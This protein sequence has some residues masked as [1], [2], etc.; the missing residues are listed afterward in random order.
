MTS[1]IHAL[2]PDKLY[3][4]ALSGG[5]DSIALAL[6]MK[7][8][9][10]NVLAL[11][12]NF[13]LRGE[14]SDRDE[15]FVRDFCHKHAIPLEVCHFDTLAS[16]REHKTSIEMEARD[17]RYRW[18]AQ[19]A[20][21]LDAEAICVAHHKDDQAETLLL[22]LIRGTGLK[23][24][25]AMHPERT[26]NGLRILR[27]L[28]DT[29]KE[30]ILNYLSHMEQDYVTDSTNLER[31]AL[32]NRIRLD[33]MPMLRQLNPNIT[34][35]LARTAHNVRMELDSDSE[36]SRYHRWLAQ[37]GFSRSQILD[38]YAHCE[39]GKRKTENGKLRVSENRSKVYFDYAEREQIQDDKVE[40]K[41]SPHRSP[42]TV[43]RSSGLTWHSATHTL[44]LDRGELILQENAQTNNSSA[45]HLQVEELPTGTVPAAKDFLNKAQAFV[46]AD[47]I[48]GELTLR[49]MRQGDRFRPYG[50]KQGSK[51]LS[52]FLTDRKVSLLD[53]QAQLVATD[54]ATNAIIWVVGREIDHRYRITPTTK[55]IL[56]LI[57]IG[58]QSTS[59]PSKV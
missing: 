32:R 57:C 8:Q 22:N 14:E 18:F 56:R 40:L 54:S 15:Q 28:L 9:H 38:I 3:L 27:P 31:D 7:E 53:K 21:A 10:L 43:H 26:V 33:L 50:M 45:F 16:A 11:H 49:P 42:L 29:T 44:L 35:C 1:I 34:D 37:L 30:E 19:R 59:T 6:M 25:A 12:C 4:I 52:D 24:L 2:S 55:R 23:G 46:D 5:A 39:N 20:Q 47:S 13:H 41:P 51:L 48:K 17:L 36:E 58:G